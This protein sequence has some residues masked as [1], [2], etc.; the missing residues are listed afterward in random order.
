ML[1]SSLIDHARSFD[2][3]PPV[4]YYYFDYT[5]ERTLSTSAAVGSL[6]QQ[7]LLRPGRYTDE[8]ER[9]IKSLY[10]NGLRSPGN[11]ELINLLLLAAKGSSSEPTYIFIDGLNEAEKG[12]QADLML[13]LDWILSSPEV[14]AKV[15]LSFRED[16]HILKQLKSSYEIKLSEAQLT[17][18]IVCYVEDTVKAKINQGLLTV[19]DQN[20]EIE[21]VGELIRK[22]C[23]M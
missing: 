21:I 20:L 22:A 16:S 23:G 1:C 15:F 6:I 5:D 7:L 14:L 18:D 3:C 12:V 19:Q 10:N 8:I 11:K 2:T 17:G 13:A 4:L 9:H